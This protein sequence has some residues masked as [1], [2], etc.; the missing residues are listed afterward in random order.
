MSGDQRPL[1]HLLWVYPGSLTEALDSATWLEPTRELRRMGWHVTLVAVGPAG[2]RVIQGVEVLFVPRPHIYLIRQLVYHA[3]ILRLVASEWSG[4]DAILFHQMS[5]LWLLPLRLPRRLA[6]R[7][8]PLLL[9]DT[10]TVPMELLTRK[11]RLRAWFYGVV[12]GLANRGADGQTAIT[13]RM[14]EAVRIPPERLWGIWPSGVN[15]DKFAA[16]Q[17]TRHWPSE[18]GPVRLVYLGALYQGR[19]L[20]SLCQAVEKA[21]AAG[22]AFAL[23]FV[24]KGPEHMTLSRFARETAG[25]I[26]VLP[27][28]P[29]D[30]VPRLLAQHHVGVL[31]FPDEAKFRVSSPVKLFEYMAAG[32]AILATEV[33][34]HTDVVKE[35]KYAIWAEDASVE[36]LFAA[37]QLIWDVRA[38]LSSMGCEAAIAAQAC[39]WQESA[40]KLSDAL[41]RGLA[42]VQHGDAVELPE[43]V[44]S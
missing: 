33:V 25:R 5:A 34:C 31:P 41:N 21:N 14:A 8:S 13:Q 35:G 19:N 29:H 30:E 28:V 9:M 23:S 27:A 3:R 18:A 16:P 43:R 17:M 4:L 6:G 1:L 39:T 15:L 11:D 2:S 36:G 32:L 20:L 44:L 12:H 24:G 26:R 22:M 42:G 37:L 38:S 10:R 7:R 40:R